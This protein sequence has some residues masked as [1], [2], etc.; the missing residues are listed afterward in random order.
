ME[1]AIYLEHVRSDAARISELAMLGLDADVPCCPGW[2]VHDL[3]KHVG[4][5]YTHK[6][7]II[8]EGW[9]E[10][11]DREMPPPDDDVV[12]WFDE[13]A[14]HLLDVLA[15]HDPN[16]PV[17]TWVE[18][19]QTVG[20]WYRRMAHESLIHRID[21][22]QALG[23]ASEIDDELA[24]D[25]I[26]EIL[27]V[28]MSGAP[29]WASLELGERVARLEI[30]GRS[31]TLRLGSFSGVSPTSGTVYT[32]EP[33]LELVGPHAEFRTVVAGPAAALD[34][35]LWGRASF[36]DVAVQGDRSIA[37]EVRAIAEEATQ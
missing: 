15:A 25:G 37:A 19:D 30:P 12:V 26:D 28:M 16:E 10:R 20:F 18:T 14:E 34:Q 23:L 13:R 32:D 7:M 3:V 33:T 17:W 31:W 9:G 35:W 21:V 8:E 6:S 1:W 24:A 36:R 27:S 5:V 4:T 29:A 22:E 2:T 11:Q